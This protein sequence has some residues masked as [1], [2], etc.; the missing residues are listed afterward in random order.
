MAKKGLDIS[1]I[2]A[3][4]KD[5]QTNL[6][7]S[8]CIGAGTSVPILPDWFSLVERLIK[9]NCRPEDKIDIDVYKG[10]GFSA[11]AMIQAVR[12]RLH[13]SDDEFIYL[14]SE[15]VYA[16]IREKITLTEW[17]SF[18]KIHEAFMLSSIT[19]KEWKDF[20][21]IKDNLLIDTSANLLAEVVVE[22]IRKEQAPKAILTFNGEAI[23]LTLLNYYYWMDRADNKNK[24][25]RIVNGI[26]YKQIDR[27]PY[28]HCHGVLPIN[29]AKP[30]KGR[31]ANE[32][33]VFL[34]ESYLQLANSPMS[35]QAINFIEN[36]MQSKMV[37]VGVSLSDP[38]M[39][40]WLSWIHNNKVQ[41]LKSNG[42]TYIES[43][44]HFW[45]NKKPKSE[46]EKIWIEESVAHLG[47]RLVWIDE[48]NQV[49][50]ALK[51]MLASAIKNKN[52]S[53]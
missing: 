8:L 33:L 23:F 47:V 51:K 14:L 5:V 9:N 52:F 41:E 29:G 44:E 27:I 46:V 38:N 22:G 1:T 13:V 32:K 3:V 50:M 25:D 4:L 20:E 48:W 16:P 45:I 11:D 15:E 24:F 40:R 37:F 26:S 12:N 35:W 49:G 39:R 34:E 10:M 2:Q 21:T 36:C 17:K 30:R 31:K 28:I 53:H 6:G 43:T 18:I 7:W 42:I 19:D